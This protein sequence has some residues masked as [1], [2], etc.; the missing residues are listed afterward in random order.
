[1]CVYV[2]ITRKRRTN[3]PLPVIVVPMS[4]SPYRARFLIDN[5]VLTKEYI[6]LFK[7]SSSVCI[8]KDFWYEALAAI[9]F[10][11]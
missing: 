2:C 5:S 11:V 6:V 3:R 7:I 8:E 9:T 1:M 10:V 4:R